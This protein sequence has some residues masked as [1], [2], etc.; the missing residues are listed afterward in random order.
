MPAG[1]AARESRRTEAGYLLNGNDMDPQT[2]PI[3]A[4]LAWV[5]KPAKDFISRDALARIQA[6]GVARKLVAWRSRETIR[7][8]TA[9]RSIGAAKR[10]GK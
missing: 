4:G 2:N 9:T 3:E 6:Q 7:S 10:S 8:E 5:V 1:V